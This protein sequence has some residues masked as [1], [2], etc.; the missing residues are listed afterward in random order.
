MTNSSTPPEP[1]GGDA[2]DFLIGQHDM[3][4]DLL[5]EVSESAGPVRQLAFERLV[6]LL[7]VHETAEEQLVHP[8]AQ[9]SV[10]GSDDLLAQRLA[11]ERE[12]KETLAELERMGPDAP[13][14][15]ALFEQFRGKVL[16]HV[17][18]EEVDEFTALRASVPAQQLRALVA[19]LKIA[20]A[21]APTHPH[22]GVESAVANYVAGPVLSLFDRT[23]D[24]ARK[25]LVSQ[26]SARVGGEER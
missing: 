16:A 2:I 18:L 7:A 3:I 13:E 1:A 22:P 21:V 10:D 6:R 25:A 20:E 4:R 8:L 17:H 23:T 19:M 5:A 9:V 26:G 15:E 11:E 14:F 12:A 24:F